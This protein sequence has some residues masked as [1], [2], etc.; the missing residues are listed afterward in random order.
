MEVEFENS[1]YMKYRAGPRY[2]QKNSRFLIDIPD[3][4]PLNKHTMLALRD[5]PYPVNVYSDDS[6]IAVVRRTATRF[7]IRPKKLGTFKLL[8]TTGVAKK[9][10]ED[11]MVISEKEITVVI[12]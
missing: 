5:M 7:V 1:T 9:G 12:R 2:V 11:N 3:K 6:R 8:V 4:V 10:T